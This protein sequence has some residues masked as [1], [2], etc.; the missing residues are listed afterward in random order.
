MK[1]AS[2]EEA[3][4]QIEEKLNVRISEASNTPEIYEPLEWSEISEIINTSKVN[5]GSHTHKH[6]ILARYDNGVI[7]NELLLS[8]KLIESKT[9][10][11]SRL[12]CYP[13]GTISDFNDK[14]KQI[15]KEAGYSCALTSVKGTN[16]E[17]S[18]LYELKRFGVDNTDLKSFILTVSGTKYFLSK[19][20]NS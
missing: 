7:R 11:K 9:G 2:I 18:D 8:K 20:R 4:Q 16:N 5:I 13:N 6:L 10:I 19:M 17:S 3:I 1:D 12:F 15:V 14:T